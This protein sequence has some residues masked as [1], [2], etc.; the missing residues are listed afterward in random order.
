[1]AWSPATAKLIVNVALPPAST[2]AVPR[3]AAPSRTVTVRVGVPA[4]GA[5]AATVAVKVTAWPGAA[6]F[7]DDARARAVAA[8][9]TVWARAAEVLFAKVPVPAKEA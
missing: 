6:G 1:M 9:L 3:M 4:P 2:V 5:T 8:R 7:S